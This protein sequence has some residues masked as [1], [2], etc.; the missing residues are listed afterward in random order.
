MKEGQKESSL[1]V[2]SDRSVWWQNKQTGE[3]EKR[4]GGAQTSND[5]PVLDLGFG[6]DGQISFGNCSYGRSDSTKSTRQMFL[7]RKLY[8]KGS[9][10]LEQ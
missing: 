3:R 6:W 10:Y 1:I 9:N 7:A 4:Q 8:G 2:W 5:T